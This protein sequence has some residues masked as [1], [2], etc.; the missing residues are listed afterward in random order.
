[1]KK[2]ILYSLITISVAFGVDCNA[3]LKRYANKPVMLFKSCTDNNNADACLCSSVA[4]SIAT[5]ELQKTGDY[6]KADEYGETTIILI[7]KACQLGSREA[8][9]ILDEAGAMR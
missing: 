3:M 8:C 4:L 6:K 5:E 1:M 7:K 2:L 9:V